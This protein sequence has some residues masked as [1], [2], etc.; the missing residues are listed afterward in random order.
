MAPGSGR[1]SPP[2]AVVF[3]LDGVVVDSEPA[4]RAS[5]NAA[6]LSIGESSVDDSE[7]RSIIGPPL[8]AG[9]SWLLEVRG[10]SSGLAGR[11]LDEYRAHYARHAM[12]GTHTYAGID[13]LLDALLAAGIPLAVATSKP[14]QFSIPI[15]EGLGLAMAFAVVEAPDATAVTEGKAETLGRVVGRL[16]LRPGCGALMVGDRR[17]D[18]EAA[19]LHGLVP[20][21]VLW[22]YGTANELRSAGA[23]FL[24]KKPGQLQAVV[25]IAT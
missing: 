25:G 10:L 24:L 16:G 20:V 2:A 1:V 17:S 23:E 15:L 8:L 11:L 22:G 6:L 18:M 9:L 19:V 4:I 7:L 13:E 3:D 12:S 21:G 5:L 14:A